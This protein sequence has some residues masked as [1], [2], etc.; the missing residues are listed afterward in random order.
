LISKS[1]QKQNLV[2]ASDASVGAMQFIRDGG[3]TSTLA[4]WGR[5]M[6]AVTALL[7]S[8]RDPSVAGIVLDSPFSRLT[9]LMKELVEE[10]KIPLWGLVGT[11]ALKLMRR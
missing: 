11:T 3:H 8:E 7:Y 1:A 2:I 9:D 10:Q 6:G 5:S 4:L